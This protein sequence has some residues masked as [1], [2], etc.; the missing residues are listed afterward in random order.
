MTD[1]GQAEHE[2]VFFV[3]LDV[4]GDRD[5]RSIHSRTTKRHKR[6][7]Y[8]TPSVYLRLKSRLI[9]GAEQVA[10]EEIFLCPDKNIGRRKE[11]EL[12]STSFET[13]RSKP[14]KQDMQLQVL[15]FNILWAPHKISYFYAQALEKPKSRTTKP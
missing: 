6:R 2:L 1:A 14:E 8:D 3:F 7:R 13:K 10:A 9:K 5:R 11:H 12:S 15:T 4:S